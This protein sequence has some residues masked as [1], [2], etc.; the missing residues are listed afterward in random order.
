MVFPRRN[1]GRPQDQIVAGSAYLRRLARL[2]KR[3]S[4][5]HILR[6]S[7]RRTR[8]RL[9]FSLMNRSA[10]HASVRWRLENTHLRRALRTG[11]LRTGARLSE[12]SLAN[13]RVALGYLELGAVYGIPRIHAS[14]E[15]LF[16]TALTR[17]TGRAPLYLEFGVYK[18]SSIRWWSDHLAQTE[19]RLVG[20]DSF[21]GLPDSWRPGLDAGAFKVDPPRISDPR[22]SFEIGWFDDTL[23]NFTPPKHDQLI[24]NIDCDLYSSTSTA[25]RWVEP[26][27]KPGTLIY[28]DELPDHDHELRALFEHRQRTKACLDPLGVSAG[29]LQ[30][31]FIYR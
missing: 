12:R 1:G 28:F 6:L 2:G 19:A 15:A 18:G 3:A 4:G 23:L 26:L 29:G 14:R 10:I 8:C 5:V 17:V 21:E 31:L 9:R 11:M 16:G 30:W 13:A 27:I 7:N 22:A 20:F 25:L 24:I